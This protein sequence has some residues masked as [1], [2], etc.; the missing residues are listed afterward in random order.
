[1]F[2]DN[3]IVVKKSEI[4]FLSVKP[5]IM[6]SVLSQIRSISSDKLFISIAMGVTLN[7]LEQVCIIHILVSYLSNIMIQTLKLLRVS[8]RHL[9]W[10]V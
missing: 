10:F 6:P 5:V 2:D 1:M 7:Q 9:V 3:E 4:V 8:L